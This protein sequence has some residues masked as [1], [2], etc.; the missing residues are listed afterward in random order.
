MSK[1]SRYHTNH[2]ESKCLYEHVKAISYLIL[3]CLQGSMENSIQTDFPSFQIMLGWWPQLWCNIVEVFYLTTKKY[4]NI[5]LTLELEMKESFVEVQNTTDI[6][7]FYIVCLY[8]TKFIYLYSMP[9]LPWPIQKVNLLYT[10]RRKYRSENPSLGPSNLYC[11]YKLGGNW[12]KNPG[13]G[14]S[15]WHIWPC[16]HF[17]VI[18]DMIKGYESLV[19]NIQFWD[20]NI[21]YLCISYPTFWSIPHYNPTSGSRDMSNSLNFKTM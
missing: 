1:R 10:G 17:G 21:I 20:F 13:A 7:R 6:L 11:T 16:G 3:V 8:Q 15:G 5:T 18:C 4:Q 19:G 12:P 9:G 2:A 14:T